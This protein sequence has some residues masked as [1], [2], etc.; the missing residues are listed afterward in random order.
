M[1]ILSSVH[2][3][4][5]RRSS[6]RSRHSWSTNGCCHTWLGLILTLFGSL[7]SR[8][9]SNVWPHWCKPRTIRANNIRPDWASWLWSF[10]DW[11][12]VLLRHR[13]LDWLLHRHLVRVEDLG[14]LLNTHR[15]G[16]GIHVR[17]GSHSGLG[18]LL[19]WRW[20]QSRR[21]CSY[22]L[23]PWLNGFRW[24]GCLAN[25]LGRRLRLLII[26]VSRVSNGRSMISIVW[27]E[28]VGN[29]SSWIRGRLNW[30]LNR[31]WS[32][33]LLRCHLVGSRLHWLRPAILWHIWSYWSWSLAR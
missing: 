22:C 25:W 11:V 16:D 30:L 5:R 4:R 33:G 13:S 15:S 27:S 24:A 32:D 31:S 23:G 17:G 28:G 21:H 18:R 19:H 20:W 2:F 10:K 6:G 8:W 1:N 29:W 12:R 3:W 7:T 9:S 14:I 26:R